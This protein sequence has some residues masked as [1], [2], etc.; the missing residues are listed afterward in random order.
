M[1]AKRNIV[2]SCG[3]SAIMLMAYVLVALM[4]HLLYV[5]FAWLFHSHV[6]VAACIIL[7]A[8]GFFALLFREH[9]FEDDDDE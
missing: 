1:S 3:L 9:I 5:L 8:F 4:G 2:Y 7:A 6:V